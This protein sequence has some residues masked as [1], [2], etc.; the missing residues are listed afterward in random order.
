M[1]QL[2][3]SESVETTGTVLSGTD[4]SGDISDATGVYDPSMEDGI[5]TTGTSLQ[6]TG[7]I[8]SGTTTNE[9]YGFVKNSTT[10]GQS[11]PPIVSNT[12]KPLRTWDVKSQLLNLIKSK[13]K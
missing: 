12:D 2:F 10:S 8:S 7:T 3:T 13:E 5:F 11:V 1:K 9:A 6:T 4:L